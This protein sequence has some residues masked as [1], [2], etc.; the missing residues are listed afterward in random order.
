MDLP[1]ISDD[2]GTVYDHALRAVE[3]SLRFGSHGLPLMGCGDWNDGMNR[4]GD[5]GLG[6]SVWLAFFQFDVLTQFSALALRQNDAA[7]ADRLLVEAGRLRGHIEHNAW[8]GEWY[9]RPTLTMEHRLDH[10]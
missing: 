2:I 7:T 1:A 8:D 4:V 3:H 9:R 10:R 5:K 6:E